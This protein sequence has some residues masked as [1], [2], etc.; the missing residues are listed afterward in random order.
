M[1]ESSSEESECPMSS[2]GINLNRDSRQMQW[3]LRRRDDSDRSSQPHSAPTGIAAQQSENFQRF[4]RAVVS[5][6]HVR[7][8]AGGRI[9]PNTRSTAPASPQLDWSS[10]KFFF[11]LSRST[12]DYKSSN[13]SAPWLLNSGVTN[14]YSNAFTTT[15][16][17]HSVPQTDSLPTMAP[18]TQLG[19]NGTTLA[20]HEAPYPPKFTSDTTSGLAQQVALPQPIKISPPSQF[21]QSKPF[22]YN[23]QLV[24]PIPPG[25]QPPAGAI[26]TLPMAVPML[27]NPGFLQQPQLSNS[28][29]F[30]PPQFSSPLT[31]ISN[32]FM[33]PASQQLPMMMPSFIQPDNMAAML[34]YL[35]MRGMAF[36]AE[37][38]TAHLQFLRNQVK[39]CDNQLAN[40]KHQI[41]EVMMQNQRA[42][43]NSQIGNIEVMLNIQTAQEG[44][45]SNGVSIDEKLYGLGSSAESTVE[46][47]NQIPPG[48]VEKKSADHIVKKKS[49]DP[50]KADTNV[51]SKTERV[52]KSRL[53]LTAALAPP[54]Q[55]RSQ[56]LILALQA[57]QAFEND[58]FGAADEPDDFE[59]QAE[60]EAR[61]LSKAT[62]DW[63]GPS[64]NT[65]APTTLS[66]ALTLYDASVHDQTND[67]VPTFQRANTFHGQTSA[68]SIS[69]LLTATPTVPYLVG[70]LP[71]G[72]Q[73]SFAKP[74]DFVYSRPL[75]DDELRARYLYW[76]KAP[77]FV[78]SGLPKFDGKDFYPPSPVKKI[79][80][81]STLNYGTT[82]STDFRESS[83][84]IPPF[85]DLFMEPGVPGYKTPSKAR[86]QQS[87]RDLD[88]V[89]QPVFT[90]GSRG[91]V[92]A[93][94]TIGYDDAGDDS[95]VKRWIPSL[96]GSIKETDLDEFSNLF[97]ERGVPGYKSPNA[98]IKHESSFSSPTRD[99]W[100]ITPKNLEFP[101]GDDCK[102]EDVQSVDSWEQNRGENRVENNKSD[103]IVNPESEHDDR[104]RSSSVVIHLSPQSRILSPKSAHE[105]AFVERVENFRR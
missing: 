64:T 5:P 77:R 9:V 98:K 29:G 71:Q 35:P 32:P 103:A 94:N 75:T 93:S 55:P 38:L 11:E 46:M 49:A 45:S 92:P 70:T 39:I 83:V 82:S 13:Q 78:Q 72:V 2:T 22:V 99:D 43:L 20:S 62:S 104:S 58:E 90:N 26:S 105:K 67:Q 14:A 42:V 96:A 69:D 7:V 53:S 76:G 33:F 21:D 88:P 6:T 84:A 50:T 51:S 12:S 60:I 59:T 16:P 101:E 65:M 61:L 23:G 44:V 52:T 18:H 97:T 25:F 4:Y 63:G 27:S 85:E 87:V 17:C 15:P 31:P 24:Y 41:D 73:A 28:C 100:P 74:T 10:D 80:R 36:P 81:S 54:F 102:E 91:C 48:F 95:P 40:N 47:P 56:A 68:A 57:Q 1:I 66:K 86:P 34:P 79:K 19:I 37:A 89:P 3:N 30:L 8:T